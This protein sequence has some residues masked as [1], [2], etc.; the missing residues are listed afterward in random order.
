MSNLLHRMLRVG[1]GRSFARIEELVG[2]V[3]AIE[4]DYRDLTD[5]ELRA[6]TDAYRR[7][8]HDGVSMNALLPEAFATVREA[9]RRTLGQRHFDE[10][11]MGGVA[12]HLGHIAEM[13]T[14]SGKTLVA[15]LPSYLN[16]LSGDGVHVVTVNDYLAG[17]DAEKIGR[18]HRFLGLSVGVVLSDMSP[19]SRRRAYLADIT[20]A[21][22]IELAFDYLNDNMAPSLDGVVQRGHNYVLIDEI[23]SVLIDEAR[24]PLIISGLSDP[25][26][27]EHGRFAT[28]AEEMVADHHYEV[29]DKLNTAAL[30]EPGMDHVEARLGID[31]LYMPEHA[32]R[33]R[34]LEN[35]LKAKEL[36]VRDRDYIVSEDEVEIVDV[37]TGRVLEGRRFSDGLHQALEAKEHVTIHPENQTLRTISAQNYFR[38]YSRMSGMTGTARSDAPEFHRTYGLD[39]VQI[40]DHK[41]SQRID[42]EDKIFRTNR[43]KFDAVADSVADRHNRGQPV[44]IGTVSVEKS[45]QLSDVLRERGIPHEVLNAR[46]IEREAAIVARAGRRGAVTVATNMAGRGTDIMLGGNPEFEAEVELRERGIDPVTDP[47]TYEREWIPVLERK[48]AESYDE[49]KYVLSIGGLCVIGTERHDSRRI[50]DQLRGRAGRQGDP[51]ETRFYL[52]LE[53]DLLQRFKVDWIKAFLRSLNVSPEEAIRSPR[54]TAIVDMA[55]AEAEAVAFEERQHVLKYDDVLDG[56]RRAFY[57][58]RRE[59]LAGNDIHEQIRT[60]IRHALHDAVMRGRRHLGEDEEE[61]APLFDQLAELYPVGVDRAAV[62]RVVASRHGWH[63]LVDLLV[64][65]TDRILAARE[66]D[67]GRDQLIDFER[68]AT[69]AVVDRRWQ[70][71]LY[72]LE[73]LRDAV[74]WRASAGRDPLVEFTAGATHRFEHMAKDI[75]A[76][77]AE[78]VLAAPAR[79]TH[80]LDSDAAELGG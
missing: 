39:V 27:D 12:L 40:P 20:Y 3:N 22:G 33:I 79:G 18:I 7:R 77:V 2:R 11:L 17:R 65:D 72:E 80:N 26:P 58:A 48:R 66:R 47:E 42:R 68:R 73:T 35:A 64:D 38:R 24:T 54:L 5:A 55:Q 74:Q 4:G 29:D 46:Y 10:Q 30:L 63:D 49:H 44:L 43:A 8:L 32:W 28:I 6:L 56:Q 13:A 31:N 71:H 61:T 70:D 36:F 76:E 21:T 52:S 78:A 41:P 9:S 16:A 50:D 51:G 69:L 23:D 59:L 57:E 67:W 25:V 14:G 60:M 1:E 15:S 45:E 53:D 34:M 75:E 37:S 62:D 19:E